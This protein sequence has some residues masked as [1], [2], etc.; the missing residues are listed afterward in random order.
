MRF[1]PSLRSFLPL[2]LLPGIVLGAP[3]RVI[4]TMADPSTSLKGKVAPSQMVEALQE[5]ARQNQTP[6]I[7]AVESLGG[8]VIERLWISNSLIVDIEEDKIRELADRPGVIDVAREQIIPVPVVTEE[9]LLI[10]EEGPVWGVTKINADKAWEKFGVDGT[11][12]TVGLIDTGV[13]GEHIDLKG[14]IVAFKDF[15]GSSTTPIDGQGHGTH[16]GGTIAGGAEGGR[17]IGVAPG[18]R[19]IV[20]RVFSASGASTADLLKSMQWIMDPDGNAKT[21]DAPQIASNSW[22][23][24]SGTDRSF[25]NAVN[26]WRAAGIFPSFA[27]GNAGSGARTVGIP[28]G[29]PHSFAAGATDQNDVIASFSSR[30]PVTWDGVDMIKPDVSAP[31]HGVISAKDGGGYRSLSGTSMACPHVTGLVALMKQAHPAATI[32][33]L[34]EALKLAVVDLGAEGPDNNY[35]TGRIDAVKALELMRRSAVAG[36]VSDASGKGIPATITVDGG[37]AV[38]A[39]ANGDFR[40]SLDGGNHQLSFAWFGHNTAQRTVSIQEGQTTDLNVSLTRAPSATLTGRVLSVEGDQAVQALI[41]VVDT[42]LAPVETSADGRF[43]VLLP[44]GAYRIVIKGRGHAVGRFDVNISSDMTVTYHLEAAKDVLLVDESSS[45]DLAAFYK[46]VLDFAGDEISY[47]VHRIADDGPIESGDAIAPYGVVIWFTGKNRSILSASSRQSLS[48]YLANGGRLLITG[49]DIGDV[50]GDTEFYKQR[51]HA[52]VAATNMGANRALTALNDPLFSGLEPF[53]I[54]GGTGAN[55]QTAP[56][57]I[58][59]A[60]GFATPL[61]KYYTLFMSR[62]AALKVAAGN[63]RVVYFGFGLEAVAD[64]EIRKDI[65]MRSLTWLKPDATEAVERLNSLEGS[66]RTNYVESLKG[67]MGFYEDDADSDLTDIVNHDAKGHLP[68]EL[69]RRALFGEV[70]GQ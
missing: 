5:Y 50:I 24:N 18:A 17:Q 68:R 27:A 62:Y 11:G 3:T 26:S 25:W 56:D 67:R 51:L 43:S 15:V 13:D 8:R 52:Q 34:E 57:A 14:K 54:Q 63:Y 70:S 42:P 38:T 30:G 36:T 48:D 47:D 58:A 23:S 16:T 33:E 46:Q 19:L 35:G 29:Y 4:V 55:N 53:M 12:V 32:E 69:K 49:Q 21:N 59:A 61:I 7:E 31:G 40:I 41:T 60:D 66:A 28:G 44:H 45:A 22:G 20:A 1:T 65:I 6:T 2:M 64:P 9:P 39:N 10:E 37:Q